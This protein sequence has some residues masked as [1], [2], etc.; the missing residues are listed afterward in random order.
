MIGCSSAFAHAAGVCVCVYLNKK[1]MTDLCASLGFSSKCSMG[2][3]RDERSND[4]C[5]KTIPYLRFIF[6]SGWHSSLNHCSCL[7]TSRFWHMRSLLAFSPAL[8]CN[9]FR[10][11]GTVLEK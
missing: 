5:W 10:T 1:H 9:S 6:R 7:F 4:K 3:M 8:K 11:D 2:M